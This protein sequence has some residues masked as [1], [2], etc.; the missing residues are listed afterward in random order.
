MPGEK[1]KKKDIRKEQDQPEETVCE[2][3]RV[4]E[5]K[6]MKEFGKLNSLKYQYLLTQRTSDVCE[7]GGGDVGM[8][9]L[10]SR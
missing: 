2:T 1:R 7:V 10:P 6:R 5:R 3:E 8:K 9:W 4:R